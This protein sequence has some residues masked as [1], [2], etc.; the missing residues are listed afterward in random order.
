VTLMSSGSAAF[1]GSVE[2]LAARALPESA[3]RH[4]SVLEQGY[5]AVM[6]GAA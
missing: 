1:R 6:Q 5:L 2:A 4:A 3:R